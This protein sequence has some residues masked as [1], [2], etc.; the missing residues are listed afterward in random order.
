MRLL[1]VTNLPEIQPVPRG[2]RGRSRQRTPS[3]RFA[4]EKSCLRY[5][6]GAIRIRETGSAAFAPEYRGPRTRTKRGRFRNQKLARIIARK[7]EKSIVKAVRKAR[8]AGLRGGDKRAPLKSPFLRLSPLTPDALRPVL[9][10]PFG[11]Y[12]GSAGRQA[13]GLGYEV[14]RWGHRRPP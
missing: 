7:R 1:G 2:G 9:V 4:A 11:F 3:R 12:R 8:T 10:A 14:I 13:C 5:T 6:A